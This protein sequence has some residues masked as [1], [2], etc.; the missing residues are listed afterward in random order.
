VDSLL[1]EIYG[2]GSMMNLTHLA[3][4]SDEARLLLNE[5]VLR[6]FMEKVTYYPM[7]IIFHTKPFLDQ[8]FYFWKLALRDVL[9]SAK[10]GMFGDKLIA[11][12]L[13]RV[14]RETIT[15]G[16][17]QCRPDYSV[18]LQEDGRVCI[19]HPESFPPGEGDI[20]GKFV[21]QGIVMIRPWSFA[22]RLTKAHSIYNYYLTI[23]DS[24]W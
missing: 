2:D 24:L 4:E 17:L 18:Y 7:G 15:P 1:E 5:K 19:F 11:A 10:R 16:W 14:K 23:S 6:P 3:R 21:G 8:G 20:K 12:F 13:N 22:T 9:H